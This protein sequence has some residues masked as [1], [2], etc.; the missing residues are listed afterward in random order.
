MLAQT[1]VFAQ[2]NGFVL[3]QMT[4][5]AAL[6]QTSGPTE[7]QV[8]REQKKIPRPFHMC[9]FL[10]FFW[11]QN[12]NGLFAHGAYIQL[13]FQETNMDNFF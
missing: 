4:H 13:Y 3:P 5:L 7:P 6:T 8:K 12:V 11:P 10:T 9:D 1:C 2:P